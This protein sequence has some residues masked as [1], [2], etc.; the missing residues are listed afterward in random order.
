VI[1]QIKLKFYLH[2]KC[3]SVKLCKL[4]GVLKILIKTL[5]ILLFLYLL[6]AFLSKF[7]F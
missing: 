5:R 1:I 4:F 2:N 3:I 6:I 7:L